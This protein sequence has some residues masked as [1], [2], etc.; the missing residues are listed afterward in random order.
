MASTVQTFVEKGCS[1]CLEGVA[2]QK[3]K[4]K[5]SGTY[6]RP[7]QRRWQEA[8]EDLVK[9]SVYAAI[10]R[11]I[12]TSMGYLVQDLLLFSSQD[13]YDG[14]SYK[15]G[16]KTKWDLVVDR[17]NAVR[18]YLEIKSGTNDMDAAQIKH[19]KDEIELVEADGHMALIGMTYGNRNDKT[20]TMG[21]LKSYLPEWEKR[22]LIGGE[23]FDFVADKK[24]YHAVLL[25]LIEQTAETLLRDENIVRRIDAKISELIVLFK[26]EYKS[27]DECYKSRW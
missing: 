9:Y 14:K 21:L 3:N 26:Q 12:V 16:A 20:V 5:R 17:V 2:T 15:E 8:A 6:Q 11:S 13:V 22:T 23:L 19:Y 27:M 25:S 7:E 24:N 4:M 1:L 18:A 10:S